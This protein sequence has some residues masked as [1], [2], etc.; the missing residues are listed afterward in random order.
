MFLMEKKMLFLRDEININ[1]LLPDRPTLQE[2]FDDYSKV[3]ENFG[4]SFKH[5]T[6]PDGSVNLNWPIGG[7][8][9]HIHVS[10]QSY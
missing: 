2:A 3:R 4:P 9:D 5:K 1:L 10:V 8:Q 7:H 6:Y